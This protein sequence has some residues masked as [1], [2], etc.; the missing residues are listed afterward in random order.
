MRLGPLG[1]AG[2][3]DSL[4]WPPSPSPPTDRFRAVREP[5]RHR[6]H[7]SGAQRSRL[8][9]VED[10]APRGA[11]NHRAL[12]ARRGQR[13]PSPRGGAA[14]D[15][16]PHR[17]RRLG[18]RLRGP[19]QL[20]LARARDRQARHVA[21]PRHSRHLHQAKGRALHDRAVERH[22]HDRGRRRRRD[23]E[24]RDCLVDLG[25]DLLQGFLFAKPGRAFPGVAW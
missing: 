3:R 4:R 24:E 15:G 2:P 23:R 8:A 22:G 17:G 25:C 16:L 20:H 21:D 19:V 6:S 10:R 14:R 7:R 13:R 5:A 12:V 18:R 1:V 11:R 9:A